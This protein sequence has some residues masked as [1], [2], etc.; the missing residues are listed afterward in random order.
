MAGKGAGGG[1]AAAPSRA[2][3]QPW[4]WGAEELRDLRA[5]SHLPMAQPNVPP[6]PK[7]NQCAALR[8]SENLGRAGKLSVLPSRCLQPA[9]LSLQLRREELEWGD[10]VAIGQRSTEPTRTCGPTALQRTALNRCVSSTTALPG[11]ESHRN[12]TASHP[13][14]ASFSAV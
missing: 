14:S 2:P 5:H 10:A 13:S 4:G 7:G 6:P 9:W 12:P 8:R 3:P 11:K 1:R